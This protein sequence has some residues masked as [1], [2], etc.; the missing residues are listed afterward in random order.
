MDIRESVTK[1][2]RTT[3]HLS[4]LRERQ[5]FDGFSS[6]AEPPPPSPPNRRFAPRLT[7]GVTPKQVY[8]IGEMCNFIA[9]ENN[10]TFFCDTSIFHRSTDERLWEAL[11]NRPGKVVIIPHVHDELGPWLATNPT[12]MAAQAIAQKRHA[13]RFFDLPSD[14]ERT[15]TAYIYYVNLLAMRKRLF[16][17]EQWRFERAHGRPPTSGRW[18]PSGATFTRWSDRVGI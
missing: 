2:T 1:L 10:L 4:S 14:D 15:K 3:R 7:W 12:H 11:L 5:G 8:D 16:D 18:R 9:M 6:L 13:I 17:V